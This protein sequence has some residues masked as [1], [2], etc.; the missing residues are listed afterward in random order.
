D[1]LA[2]DD[3]VSLEEVQALHAQTYS[4]PAEALRPYLL[5]VKPENDRVSPGIKFITF[6]FRPSLNLLDHDQPIKVLGKK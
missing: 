2:A 4:L 1:L 6:D 3:R 5:K